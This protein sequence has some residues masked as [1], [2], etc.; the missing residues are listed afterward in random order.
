MNN[1]KISN[2][3]KEVPTGTS[4]NEKDYITCLLT[5]LKD[6]EKNYAIAMTEASNKVLYDKFKEIFEN[7]ASLQRETYEL[8]FKNGW[9]SLEKADK[10]KINE[11]HQ[12][13]NSEYQDLNI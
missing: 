3:K 11:K 8:M 5:I 13:L 2:P 12:M 4:M 1:N 10:K 6:M 7:I 9:Y